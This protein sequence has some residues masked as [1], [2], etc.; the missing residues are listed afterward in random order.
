[1]KIAL[2]GYYG[3]NNVGDELLLEAV[4]RGLR[5]RAPGAQP[6][7][8]SN[9]PRRT[10]GDHGVPAVSRW[11]PAAV[12]RAVARADRLMFGGGGIFQDRTS[13]RSLVYYT[14]LVLLARA[15]RT[16]VVL[17]AVGVD[18]L[19]RFGSRGVVRWALGRRGVAIGV[20]DSASAAA[21]GQIG[22][23]EGVALFSDLVFS[24]EMPAVSP[25]RHGALVVR[26][27]GRENRNA[28]F[29]WAARALEQHGHEVDALSFQ[30]GKDADAGLAGGAPAAPFVD[31]REAPARIA[32]A[33]VVISARFHALV[34]A[35]LAGRPFLGIG[36][37]SSK[38]QA[39]CAQLVMPFVP[40]DA[41]R[42]QRD[43]AVE[44]L[45]SSPPP[46]TRRVAALRRRAEEALD[47]ALNVL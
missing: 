9:E 42:A 34:L 37:P 45:F 6:V 13:K 16:P 20:R 36:D 38:V 33:S 47:D 28:M 32:S 41:T 43:V 7:V 23:H 40:W 26:E 46:D 19:R 1:M 4:L 14:G 24:L 17:C 35:A 18:T 2:A 8:L 39:L 29:G 3:F 21:L 44:H 31:F 25:G 15:L 11:N 22:V 12:A 10:S 30:P 5:K 27:T